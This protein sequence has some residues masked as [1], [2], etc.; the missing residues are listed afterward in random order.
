MVVVV[1]YLENLLCWVRRT[2][3]AQYI[4]AFVVLSKPTCVYIVSDTDLGP[5]K[6]LLLSDI[7]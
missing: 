7:I 3:I 5:G 6:L 2:G 1:R 4:R